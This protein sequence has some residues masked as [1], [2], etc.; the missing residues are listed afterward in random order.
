MG[1]NCFNPLLDFDIYSCISRCR[2]AR[3]GPT[4]EAGQ[5]CQGRGTGEGRL[6]SP[7]GV[8]AS[9]ETFFNFFVYPSRHKGPLTPE[10]RA[11]A[12]R[13]F[14]FIQATHHGGGL[15]VD[16]DVPRWVRGIM[17]RVSAL[18]RP[19]CPSEKTEKQLKKNL[20]QWMNKNLDILKGH[21]FQVVASC[22]DLLYDEVAFPVAVGWARKRY[23]AKLARFTIDQAR[24]VFISNGRQTGTSFTSSPPP[25][26]S[27][28]DS[29][30][31]ASPP[32]CSPPPSLSPISPPSNSTN[33]PPVVVSPPPP[34]SRTSSPVRPPAGLQARHPGPRG[35]GLR[36]RSKPGPTRAPPP[37]QPNARVVSMMSQRPRSN[38]TS[39][40][41]A[42]QLACS[43]PTYRATGDVGGPLGGPGR[44][45]SP[46]RPVGSGPEVLDGGGGGTIAL[47]LSFIASSPPPGPGR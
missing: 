40:S 38:Y 18:F 7:P 19:A 3:R 33:P 14:K 20:E 46:G 31:A 4:M 36:R 21:Y 43:D 37:V 27:L 16:T 15:D 28:P 34:S 35:S 45:R 25:S 47:N 44:R 2:L 32:A 11:V 24:E 29:S 39:K 17:V 9:D 42:N 41:K 22:D 30:L 1:P 10:T 12:K 13:M 6:R 26:A 5:R 8:E 23:K